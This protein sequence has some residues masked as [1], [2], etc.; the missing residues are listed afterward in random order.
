MLCENCHL[1]EAEVKLAVKGQDGVNEK[2]V[3]STC[4]RVAI[5]GHKINSYN[6]KM[7]LKAHLW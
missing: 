2:W 3:C 6:P 7:I 5:L 1:N 4:A